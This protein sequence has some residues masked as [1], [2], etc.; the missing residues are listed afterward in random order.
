MGVQQIR[1]LYGGEHRSSRA[2][3]LINLGSPASPEVADVKHYLTEFLMDERVISISYFWRALLVKG[4][5]APKRAPYSARNYNYIWEE[6]HKTFPLIRHSATIA[7]SLSKQMSCPVALAMR[8]GAPSMDDALC[9][10]ATLGLK[11]VVAIPLYPHYTRSSYETAAVYALERNKRLGLGLNLQ[12]LPPFYAH[13][14]YRRLL[15]SSI[16]PYLSAPFDKLIVSL[17]GIPLSHLSAVCRQENGETDNCLNR[18]HTHAEQGVCYR[19]HCE[20][21]VAQLCEDL[22]LKPWQ[23][24]LV[25]QSRLGR[26]EWMKPYFSERIKTLTQDNVR[27]VLV[28]CPGFICDCLETIHEIDVEY[29]EEFLSSGGESF[30]YIPCLNSSAEFISCLSQMIREAY[31]CLD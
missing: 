11:E 24:E 17:H 2:I 26:H 31:P 14:L 16:R 3:L 15:A 13:P 20:S 10:L 21:T 23:V 1:S 9:S 6:E 30:T 18:P 7:E 8:Y 29:R 19:L 27:R 25:Y 28:V 4:I 22:A 5:I 12:L